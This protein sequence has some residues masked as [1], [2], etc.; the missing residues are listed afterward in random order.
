MKK[1]R[2]ERIIWCAALAA[3]DY[4]IREGEDW[5]NA[6]KCMFVLIFL[7]SLLFL[8]N[9]GGGDDNCLVSREN[10]TSSYKQANYGTTDISCCGDMVCRDSITAGVLVCQ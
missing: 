1:R 8:A 6:V 3:A 7:A 4:D 10:C 2:F 9:C 5:M